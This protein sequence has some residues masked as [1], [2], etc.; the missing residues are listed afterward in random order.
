[1]NKGYLYILLATFFFSSMEIALKLVANQ[2]NPI[3]INFIRFVI[4][5]I[6]LWP[7]AVKSLKAAH[8]KLR[9]FHLPFFAVTG[10]LCVVVS[11]TFFQMAIV[12]AHASLVAILFSCN[13]AFVIPLAHLFLKEKMTLVSVSSLFLSLVGMYFIVNPE[14]IPNVLGVSFSLLA[15]ITF[16]LYG[17][18]GQI[19]RRRYGFNGLSL[20]FFSF[21]AGCIEMFVLMLLT[22][23][24]AIA[25]SLTLMGFTDFANIPFVQ[26]ITLQSIP[27]LIYLGVF[28]TG[29]GYSLY[30][31]AMDETSAS[32]ASIVFFIKPALAPLMAT[33]ILGDALHEN[34]IVGIVFIVVGSCL[35]FIAQGYRQYHQRHS[36][37]HQYE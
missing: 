35:T 12:Y 14:H 17:I 20:T 13:A 19:G 4:G 1:M 5:S 31:I 9:Y 33:F 2:F 29:L 24:P 16:A 10:F 11:M 25:G 30:F 8:L 23:I 32:T 15:A 22:H 21:V 26:G 6:V 3:Q 27:S 7:M 37:A 28:V 18:L 36:H 34:T